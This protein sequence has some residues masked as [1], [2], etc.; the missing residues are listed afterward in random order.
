M[1]H[2]LFHSNT[3]FSIHSIN[4][5]FVHRFSKAKKANKE[6]LMNFEHIPHALGGLVILPQNP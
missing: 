1:I 4:S 5:R 3:H 6:K 2:K